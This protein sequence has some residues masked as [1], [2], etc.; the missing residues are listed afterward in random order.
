ML[1]AYRGG[2]DWGRR[3]ASGIDVD[4]IVAVGA[5]IDAG[6][7]ALKPLAESKQ[8]TAMQTL[9]EGSIVDSVLLMDVMPFHVGARVVQQQRPGD[10]PQIEAVPIC[11]SLP[12][13]GV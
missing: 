9:N 3:I 5:A 2:E 10:R 7:L 6:V 11:A 4:E 1:V 12:A 13:D 8:S